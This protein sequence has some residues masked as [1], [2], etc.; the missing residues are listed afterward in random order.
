MSGYQDSRRCQYCANLID[1]LELCD[2]DQSIADHVESRT[3][4]SFHMGSRLRQA[5]RRIYV[6]E[7]ELATLNA[8][9]K[10]TSE[11]NARLVAENA[12]L[13]QDAE[14][15]RAYKKRKDDVIAAGMGRKILRDAARKA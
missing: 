8:A 13:K 9:L 15:W 12:A 1:P 4:D 2:C 7:S 11:G 6:L 10:T 14:L 5:V 3:T